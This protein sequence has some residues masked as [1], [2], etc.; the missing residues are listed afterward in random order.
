[1]K[2]K[3]EK[4]YWEMNAQELAA[5]TAELN[6]EFVID[7]CAPLSP[8]MRAR[9]EK[10]KRKIRRGR[11]GQGLRMISVRLEEDL[12]KRSEALAK[13]IGISRDGLIARGL[14][15]I[16]VAAGRSGRK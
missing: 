15:A 3:R 7:K 2:T 12:L 14:N 9:W 16:L 10:A 5:A 1:M 11:N 6:Q 4:P 8:E 13:K